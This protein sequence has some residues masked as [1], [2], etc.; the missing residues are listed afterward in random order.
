MKETVAAGHT[1]LS[2]QRYGMLLLD[3]FFFF[4]SSKLPSPDLLTRQP[5]C[6]LNVLNV[7]DSM[8]SSTPV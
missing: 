4:L 2:T 3:S 6:A 5:R 1:V 7:V 8:D